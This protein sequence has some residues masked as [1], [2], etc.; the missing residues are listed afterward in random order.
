MGA[1]KSYTGYLFTD[2]Q[3]CREHK[4]GKSDRVSVDVDG[5][6]EVFVKLINNAILK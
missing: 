5:F 3:N 4:L 1:F 2:L 6:Q